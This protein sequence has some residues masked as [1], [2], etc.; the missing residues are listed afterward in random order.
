MVCFP[1][2]CYF[3]YLIWCHLYFQDSRYCLL[4]NLRKMTPN[5]DESRQST[6]IHN[7]LVRTCSVVTSMLGNNSRNPP[8]STNVGPKLNERKKKQY[9]KRERERKQ[10]FFE[11]YE[12][13]KTHAKQLRQKNFNS[14]VQRMAS[15]ISRRKIP[16][17]ASKT[18]DKREVGW[19]FLGPCLEEF[20]RND[21]NN[22]NC[23]ATNGY[24]YVSIVVKLKGWFV[25]ANRIGSY[26]NFDG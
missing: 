22:H 19:A 18:M 20:G 1:L 21:F 9:Q 3:S 26:Q 2:A 7:D 16:H 10:Q 13:L 11:N 24:L 23:L 15:Q 14:E 5:D 12:S 8:F 17:G 4:E 25:V 6:M